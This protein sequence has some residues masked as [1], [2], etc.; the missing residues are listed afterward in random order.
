MDATQLRDAL[1]LAEA[2][3]GPREAAAV[4][5]Q[6][7]ASL[8]VVVVDAQDM[9]GELPAASGGRVSIWLGASEGHCWS[10]T[11]DPAQASAL[12][13]ADRVAS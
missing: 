2:S 9:R 4:L 12:F 8:R 3:P 13:V 7:F 1:K 5:R 10:V 6:R 11:L